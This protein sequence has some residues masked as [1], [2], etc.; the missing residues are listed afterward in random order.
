M[1]FVGIAMMVTGYAETLRLILKLKIAPVYSYAGLRYEDAAR[2]EYILV[3]LLL[4]AVAWSLPTT[5]RRVGEFGVWMVYVI[6]VIPSTVAILF[7]GTVAGSSRWMTILTIAGITIGIGQLARV[8]FLETFEIRSP[9]ALLWYLLSVIVIGIYLYLAIAVGIRTQYLTFSDVYSVRANYSESAGAAP[10]LGYLVPTLSNV[11]NPL[12]MARGLYQRRWVYL[13]A[14]V[15]GQ[16]LIYLTTGEKIVL[17]SI[18]A[19]VLTAALLRGRRPGPGRLVLGITT[20]TLMAIALDWML[21]SEI[22]TSLFVRR[23]LILPGALVGA[24]VWVFQDAAKLNFS[25]DLLPFLDNPYQ[26]QS[27]GSIVGGAFIGDPHSNAVV[28]FFGHGFLNAGYAGMAVEG[29]FFGLLLVAANT[30]TQ[31]HSLGSAALLFVMPIVGITNSSIFTATLTGGFLS[32]IVVALVLPSD[33]STRRP[34]PARSSRGP[35]QPI[36]VGSG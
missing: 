14:G 34:K 24:Y 31:R 18:G 10:I 16:L 13:V 20:L 19:V 32:A 26:T 35:S 1:A 29:L 5:F 3:L 4:I 15:L 11:L 30:V 25:Q 2:P 23:F 8:R 28:N 21:G 6:S 12:L 22:F 36:Q 27:P 17:L 7:G 33:W 9:P